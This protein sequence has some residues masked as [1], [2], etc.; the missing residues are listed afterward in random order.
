MQQVVNL[1]AIPENGVSSKLDYLVIGSF[2]SIACLN[3]EKSSE[4]KKVEARMGEGA[5]IQIVS[6]DF[7]VDLV[8]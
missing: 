3:G 4:L 2:D 1:G 5:P 7:L 6:E 8:S